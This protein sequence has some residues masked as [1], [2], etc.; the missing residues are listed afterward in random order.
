MKNRISLH[1]TILLL[2]IV[3]AGCTQ[4]GGHIGKLFG[5][6]HLERIEGDNMEA[7]EQTGNI[8]WSFQS[9]MIL[10]QR[11]NG[12]IDFSRVYGTYRLE[13]NTL[14]LDFPEKDKTPMFK[15]LGLPK[16][17]C[18]CEMQVLKL[19]HSEFILIYNPTPDTSL[20]YYLKKW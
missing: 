12:E 3:S 18:K 14:F 6:W 9:D 5:R 16:I 4:N 1:L 2:L 10:L 8:Y 19:T 15:Q 20:T 11:E 7:P 13:D 17:P